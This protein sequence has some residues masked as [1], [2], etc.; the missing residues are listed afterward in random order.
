MTPWSGLMRRRVVVSLKSGN[1]F[2][3]VC[4]RKRGSLLTLK[5][6]TGLDEHSQER[7]VDGEVVVLRENIDYIQVI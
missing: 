1:G 6:V 2:R 4:Y 7:P 3:G 5:D